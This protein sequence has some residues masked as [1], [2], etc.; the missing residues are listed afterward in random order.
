M[1]MVIYSF[2]HSD[3]FLDKSRKKIKHTDDT[4][5][6]SATEEF[7][8]VKRQPNKGPA[9]DQAFLDREKQDL[10]HGHLTQRDASE[11]KP[12]TCTPEIEQK[13]IESFTWTEWKHHEYRTAS[14]PARQPR[15]KE[16]R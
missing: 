3:E 5:V 13:I 1:M 4:I 2:N 8:V 9:I 7:M 16:S 10:F 14:V 6:D 12:V 11:Y 15:V